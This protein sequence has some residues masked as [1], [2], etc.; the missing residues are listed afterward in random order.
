MNSNVTIRSL[1][2]RAVNVPLEYPVK[3]AVGIVA[4]S[5]LILIDL[6]TS[7]NVTGR[8]YVFTYTPTALKATGQMVKD[9]EQIL[10]GQPLAPYELDRLLCAR[11]RLIG[12]TGLVRMAMAGIDMAAWDA[13]AKLHEV[14]LVTLLGGTPKKIPAYD[15]HSMDGIEVG[16]KRAA[17]AAERGYQAIKTKIGYQTL[18][19][20]LKIVR[21]L[22]S[23]IGDEVQLMVD[24]NQGLT[25]PEA[26]RRGKA[27]EQENIAWIE[28]PTLQQDY[29]GHAAIRQALNIPVQM[30]ENWFGPDEMA[31]A[32]NAG[33]SDFAM[34]DLMKIGGVT[35]WL[36]AAALAEQKGIPLS[37]H[38][39]QEFSAHLLA[40]SPTCHWIERMDLAGAITEP[41]LQFKDG[42]AIVPDMPGAGLSWRESEIAKYL[43]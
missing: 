29:E 14:P 19:E 42:Q 18:D 43:V 17:E 11:F 1:R 39:F 38:I 16:S 5:P 36:R 40:V 23:I 25:I 3:T 33:A 41:T 15:S 31:K 8:A 22:R 10:V 21:T 13:L 34:P 24:Y 32:I 6:E 9:L 12:T 20:D 27:L 7:A 26:I 35:G 37:S 28:E 4:T 2:V 30:G